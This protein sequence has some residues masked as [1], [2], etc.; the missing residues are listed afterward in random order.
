MN[1]EQAPKI[2]EFH[3]YREYIR[4]LI[5]YLKTNKTFSTRQFAKRS[6]FKSPS[7]LKM[8]LDGKRNLSTASARQLAKGFQLNNSERKFLEVLVLFNQ[9]KSE[10]EKEEYYKTLLTFRKFLKIQ[11]TS[12]KQYE[13]FSNW[14][15]VAIREA[16]SGSWKRKSPSELAQALGITEHQTQEAILLL[17]RLGMI[18]RRSEHYEATDVSLETPREMRNILV[19]AFHRDMIKKALE[20]LEKVSEKER[21]LSG[22][23]IALTPKT[24]EEVK[25][26]IAHFRR[27]L[28]AVYSGDP[29]AKNVYQINVQ[30][31]PLLKVEK[32]KE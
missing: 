32:A 31:F 16:L 9:A 5:Q 19:R 25:K 22:L 4:S 13:Y 14:Y 21:D 11:K 26:R 24:Y 3:D 6:G 23:T 1:K 30:V 12:S 15:N 17:E 8:V 7:Y 18:V 29:Q 10:S 2:F 27:E 28:N 20:S